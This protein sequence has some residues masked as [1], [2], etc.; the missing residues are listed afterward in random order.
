M[1]G[2]VNVNAPVVLLYDKLPLPL[3]VADDTLKL[4]RAM[5]ADGVN[6]NAPVVLL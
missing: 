5:P 1:S 3:A 2:G 6:V 4:V